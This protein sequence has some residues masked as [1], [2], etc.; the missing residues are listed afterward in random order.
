MEEAS[1]ALSTAEFQAFQKQQEL[2]N[3]QKKCKA[4]IQLAVSK[5]AV[6]Y[7][8]QLSSATQKLQAKD[9]AMQKLQDQVR[10]LEISL[11][12]Q[13]N[14]PSVAQSKEEV[15][16]HKEVFNCMPGTGNMKWGTATYQSRDQP[17][18]FQKQVQF[19]D[20]SPVPDLK[21]GADPE[22]QINASHEVPVTSMPYCDAKAMNKTFDV[23]QIS[24]LSSD[25]QNTAA[26]AAEVS[27][28]S[29]T[30]ASREFCCMCEPKITKCKGGYSADAKLLFRS[31]WTDI[32][33]NIQY[34]ELDNKAAIQLIK[35]MTAEITCCEVEFQLDLCSGKIS[36][37]DLLKHLS[38]TFQ[39]GKDE[40]NLL[41]EFYSHWQKAEVGRSF[42]WWIADSSMQGN[43]QKALFQTRFGH[44]SEA[45]LC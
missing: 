36:Y 4:D 24:P 15:N 5:A 1:G 22:D 30:Q 37:Q 42:C 6:Q 11:A 29:A 43:Q 28:A 16:L 12:S 13:T 21:L 38:V 20:R 31:W 2:I 10:T 41:T 34:C 8:E 40:A 25:H 26:I 33:S 23:S 32:L 39:G 14:L 19:G 3:L 17:F 45:V 27:A 7:K 18:Q 9:Q 44:K 35:D